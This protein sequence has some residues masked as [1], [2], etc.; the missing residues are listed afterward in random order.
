VKY[1]E[2]ADELIANATALNGE[3]S[4]LAKLFSETEF[5]GDNRHFPHAHY[6]YLMACMGQI[7]LMSKCEWGPVEPARNQTPR[8]HG[9]LPRRPEG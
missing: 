1:A 8:M 2:I 4:S 9:A 6:G 7:D 3:V 5:L